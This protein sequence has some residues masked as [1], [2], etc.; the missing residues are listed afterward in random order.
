MQS[1][2]SDGQH[3]LCS[4]E[5]TDQVMPEEQNAQHQY[6]SHAERQQHQVFRAL[7]DPICPARTDILPYIGGGGSA[8]GKV[9]HHGKAVH[10]HDGHTGSNDGRAHGIGQTLD[11]NSGKGK[12]RLCNASRNPQRTQPPNNGPVGSQRLPVHV[13]HTAH[14]AQAN[15]AHDPGHGLR[16]NGRPGHARYAHAELADE[17]NVQ[18]DVQK[19]GHQQRD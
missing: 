4:G 10:T 7:M 12:N 17:Q 18:H 1:P 19:A 2:L 5:Q 14:P 13:H 11:D 9:G 3:V 15:Q 8:E 6:G 16:D